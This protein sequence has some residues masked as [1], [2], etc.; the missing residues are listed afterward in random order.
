MEKELIVKANGNKK[1]Q[2][3]HKGAP[4]HRGGLTGPQHLEGWCRERG[5]EIFLGV[6]ALQFLNKK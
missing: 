1:I 2:Q 4:L 5:S 6:A 3:K